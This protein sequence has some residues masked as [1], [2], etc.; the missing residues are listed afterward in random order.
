M[1]DSY[2]PKDVTIAA[3]ALVTITTP[4]PPALADDVS[5]TNRCKAPLCVIDIP[6]S[7][8]SAVDWDS[9]YGRLLS[10]SRVHQAT[11]VF[12]PSSRIPSLRS[13]LLSGD[14]RLNV[15]KDKHKIQVGR[16][17]GNILD[18][19]CVEQIVEVGQTRAICEAMTLFSESKCESTLPLHVVLNNFYQ[20]IDGDPGIDTIASRGVL[21]AF[22]GL[23][24]PRLFELGAA[25]NR[26]RQLSINPSL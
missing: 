13:L 12:L 8:T 10:S 26:W 4:A 5:I 24:R 17:V 19:S 22:G 14:D 16:D 21:P 1:I 9:S 25:I 18:L 23:T 20:Q 6:S 2:V 15:H 3:K 11:S 7:A